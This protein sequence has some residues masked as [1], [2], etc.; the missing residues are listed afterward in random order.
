LRPELA[1]SAQSDI[2]ALDTAAV[3]R[4][5]RVAFFNESDQARGNSRAANCETADHDRGVIPEIC[6]CDE[7]FDPRI[8]LPHGPL[9]HLYKQLA[10]LSVPF[11]PM[12][13]RQLLQPVE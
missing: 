9:R 13:L 2:G 4:L 5:K 1:L 10:Q 12:P 6:G 3:I 8:G 7:F 11:P